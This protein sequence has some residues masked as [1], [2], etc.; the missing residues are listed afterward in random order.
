MREETER[1]PKPLVD[2]G[3]RPILWHLM[4]IY[5]HY[6][7]RRFI[8]CLGYKSW[9]IKEYFLRY[10]EH[11]SD[12]TLR[13]DDDHKPRFN[14][15]L[16]DEEWEVTCAETGLLTASGAR[17]W[18]VRDYIEQDTFLFTYGD[19]LASLD[20]SELL[21][22]HRQHGRIGTITGVHPSS[23]YGEMRVDGDVVT[24]FNE[25]P[26]QLADFVSGGFFVFERGIFD[27][28]HDDP[29]LVFEQEPLQNLARDGQLAVFRHEGFWLGMDTHRD[30]VELNRLWR[31]GDAPWKKWVI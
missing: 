7:F 28:L 3:G 29:Q 15:R 22:F 19:G 18:M 23:R 6:R 13:L 17:L 25:K 10:K 16:G 27:Y 4:K 21:R 26:T 24:E 12:F 9:D 11:L 2:I 5:D 31:D 20:I 8:L 14:D 30:F 1:I